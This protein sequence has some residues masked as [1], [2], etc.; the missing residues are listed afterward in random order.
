MASLNSP[1][2]PEIEVWGWPWHGL[3]TRTPSQSAGTL[4]AASGRE[5]PIQR[6][7]GGWTYLWDIGMP[8]APIF[9]DSDE[10]WWNVS[11]LRS[12]GGV[13][14]GSARNV[15]VV[16]AYGG[17][18]F[19][20]G[21]IK[22]G[23]MVGSLGL[24]ADRGGWKQTIDYAV[25]LRYGAETR[26]LAL[27]L[28]IP[29]IGVPA[30]TNYSISSALIDRSPDGRRSL[31]RLAMGG[32]FGCVAIVE[33]VIAGEFENP[34]ASLNV[35]AGYSECAPLVQLVSDP[36]DSGLEY[37]VVGPSHSGWP[38]TYTEEWVAEAVAGGWYDSDGSVRLVKSISRER[39]TETT[40]I[41]ST[42][43]RDGSAH[44]TIDIESSVSLITGAATVGLTMRSNCTLSQVGGQSAGGVQHDYAVTTLIQ[45]R[46]VFSATHSRFTANEWGYS[47]NAPFGVARDG[48]TI[49]EQN[50]R[51]CR[52]FMSAGTI[53]H[54]L[55]LTWDINIPSGTLLANKVLDVT[56]IY[57][58]VTGV[59]A[60]PRV[61]AISAG[62]SPAGVDP[63]ELYDGGEDRPPGFYIGAYNPVTGDV[64]RRRAEGEFTWV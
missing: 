1:A 7:G 26:E 34:S 54:S 48:V 25:L 42:G 21:P 40:A 46:T 64:V 14:P 10:Q 24:G 39:R 17:I 16:L 11:I 44:Q 4:V 61:R 49:P 33:L 36:A 55:G 57:P 50:L 51:F 22:L 59:Y 9:E 20:G 15:D 53:A 47:G 3:I 52:P 35:I 30:A 18:R 19:G 29:S 31:L 28:S 5:V 8:P 41:T 37:V 13:I 6:F 27:S 62:V 63:G 2:D 58:E 12:A 43:P 38:G 60:T 23:E 32:S 56:M 45:D